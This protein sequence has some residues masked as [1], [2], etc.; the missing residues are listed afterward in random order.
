MELNIIGLGILAVLF[1]LLLKVLKLEEAMKS[2]KNTLRH[3]NIPEETV[4]KEVR[5]LID[6]GEDIK[7]IKKTR[8][9]FGYSLVEAKE[10]VDA[11]KLNITK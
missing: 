8:E 4:N 11:L 5:E 7:A 10:Y 2:I 1:F 6:A 9:I 3:I